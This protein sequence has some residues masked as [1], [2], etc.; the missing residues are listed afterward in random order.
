MIDFEMDDV[1]GQYRY[2][3]WKFSEMDQGNGNNDGYR[4]Q[5][6]QFFITQGIFFFNNVTGSLHWFHF[7]NDNLLF[8]LQPLQLQQPLQQLLQL[9]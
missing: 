4:W 1:S 5:T 6:I 8:F 9:L 7:I 3:I 2:Y